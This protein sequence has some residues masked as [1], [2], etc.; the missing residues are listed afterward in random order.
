MTRL[1]TRLT[2]LRRQ[3]GRRGAALLVFAFVDFALAWSLIDP[4]NAAVTA[5]QPSYRAMAEVAPLAF[6]GWVW[7]AVGF[8]CLAAALARDDRFGFGVAIGIKVV[9]SGCFVAS[10]LAYDVPRAWVGAALWGVVAALVYLI[11]GWPEPWDTEALED[12]P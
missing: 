12:R 11:A 10:W 5:A 7:V 9:W 2:H 4:A 3:T 8:V 6:W 1:A